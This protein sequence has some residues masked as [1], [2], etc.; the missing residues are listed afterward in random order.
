MIA[1]YFF[2]NKIIFKSQNLSK[3][4]L[5]LLHFNLKFYVV[6]IFGDIKH[7]VNNAY[8]VRKSTDI[9]KI[10]FVVIAFFK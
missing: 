7:I 5:V 9:T 3:Q 10:F 2:M 4:V 1:L 8:C 6:N